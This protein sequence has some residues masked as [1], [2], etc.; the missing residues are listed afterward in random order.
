MN[1]HWRSS[2]PSPPPQ[3]DKINSLFSS[4]SYDPFAWSL[5]AVGSILARVMSPPLFTNTF[6]RE[7]YLGCAQGHVLYFYERKIK[8]HHVDLLNYISSSWYYLIR[9]FRTSDSFRLWGTV[10]L[11]L[12]IKGCLVDTSKTGKWLLDTT[13]IVIYLQEL[14][15]C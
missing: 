14:T 15:I 6:S 11:W 13:C 2:H 9:D 5:A 12:H 4:E 10:L 3:L 1:Q 8:L 7:L